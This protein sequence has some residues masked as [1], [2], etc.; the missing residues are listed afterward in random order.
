MQE[1]YQAA[2]ACFRFTQRVA[3]ASAALKVGDG[4]ITSANFF[5]SAT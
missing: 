3:F 2:V 5:A 1:P 4:R